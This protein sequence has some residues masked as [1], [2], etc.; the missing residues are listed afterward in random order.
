[1][2]G[3]ATVHCGPAKEGTPVDGQAKERLWLQVQG[4]KGEGGGLGQRASWD[5]GEGVGRLG[6]WGRQGG[7]VVTL[8]TSS[9]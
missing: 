9:S 8:V 4:G 7:W 1:M 5:G 3:Q 6:G 2:P